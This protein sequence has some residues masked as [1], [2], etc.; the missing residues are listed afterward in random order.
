MYVLGHRIG[1]FVS[2]IGKLYILVYITSNS[3]T[4]SS[5]VVEYINYQSSQD[6]HEDAD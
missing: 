2:L 1:I 3:D 4:A 6:S 5:Y